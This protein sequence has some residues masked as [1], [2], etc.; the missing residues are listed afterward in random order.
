MNERGHDFSPFLTMKQ[1]LFRS[2]LNTIKIS[3]QKEI[4]KGQKVD[5]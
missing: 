4:E 3:R 5:S 2:F 1:Y